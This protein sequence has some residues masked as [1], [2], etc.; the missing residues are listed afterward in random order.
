GHRG[1]ASGVQIPERQERHDVHRVPFRH[2]PSRPRSRRHPPAA[3]GD[4]RQRR[5]AGRSGPRRRARRRAG[6]S[7]GR[8]LRRS[9]RGPVRADGRGT[10]AADHPRPPAA[11]APC[12]SPPGR[13]PAQAARRRAAGGL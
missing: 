13:P 4:A 11:P 10:R 2:H 5:R 3:A 8:D 6:R 9:R 1:S 12:A 7:R